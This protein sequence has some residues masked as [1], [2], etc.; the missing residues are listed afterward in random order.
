MGSS[1]TKSLVSSFSSNAI[2]SFSSITSLNDDNL[3]IFNI[4]T[5]YNGLEEVILSWNIDSEIN[6]DIYIKGIRCNFFDTAGLRDADNL[7]EGLYYGYL[8]INTNEQDVA[9]LGTVALAAAVL[10]DKRSSSTAQGDT[11]AVTVT[12]GKAGVCQATVVPSDKA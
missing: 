3:K 1:Y 7:I 9:V 8:L 12:V 10:L 6:S 4:Q 2:P 5:D 11:G